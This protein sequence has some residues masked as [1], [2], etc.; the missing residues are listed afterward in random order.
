MVTAW[1]LLFG[2]VIMINHA[3]R[4]AEQAAAYWNNKCTP[5]SIAEKIL[6]QASAKADAGEYGYACV[7]H[8]T[9]VPK[10]LWQII[11]LDMKER[12]LYF[13]DE[14]TAHSTMAMVSAILSEAGLYLFMP[15]PD[16]FESDDV[17]ISRQIV[18]IEWSDK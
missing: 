8:Y 3:S 4:F 6:E 11:D 2:L 17:D 14:S 10:H 15:E 13:K 12:L 9:I 16:E 7:L 5:Q 18:M 1:L